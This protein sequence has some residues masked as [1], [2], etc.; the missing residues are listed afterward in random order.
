VTA[1]AILEIKVAAKRSLAIMTVGAGVVAVGEV[2]ER[3]GRTDLSLLRETGSV[4]M[5]V[6]AAKPLTS[7]MLRVTECQA[8]C[9]RVS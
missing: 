6:R 5:T 7:A 8:E 1:A 9:R 3:P 2:Y 4:V